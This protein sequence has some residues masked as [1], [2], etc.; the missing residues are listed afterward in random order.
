VAITGNAVEDDV[1]IQ[2]MAMN[3]PDGAVPVVL[4]SPAGRAH[5]RPGHHAA[6][7]DAHSAAL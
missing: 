3:Q 6:G 1:G 7:A 2:L 4:Q 5:G